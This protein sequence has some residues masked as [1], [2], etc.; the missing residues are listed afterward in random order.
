M[1]LKPYPKYKD[2]GIEWLGEIPEGWKVIPIRRI[3]KVI[4][5]ST[6]ESSNEEFWEGH[7]T[8]ITPEDLGNNQAKYITDSKR[9]ITNKGYKYC[10]TTLVP[11][12]SLIISTRAPIG[13]LALSSTESCF[14]QGCRGI[15]FQKKY[16]PSFYYYFLWATKDVLNAYGQGTTFFELGANKLA[17]LP[18]AVPPHGEQIQI[19]NYLDHQ[20]CKIDELIKK[21]ERLIELLKEK[22]QA[23][24]SHAV[25]KGLDPNAKMKDS[26]IEWLGEIPEGWEVRK[27]KY[28]CI[29]NFQ[30]GAN[31]EALDDNPDYPRYIRIT[32]I[33]DD[34]LRKDTF[35]SLQKDKA[36]LF[37]LRKGDILFARS[38]AT[39][40]KTFQYKESWGECCY[41]GYLIKMS[42]DPSKVESDFI[43]Y[44]TKSYS[45]NSWKTS[46]FIQAT[47]QNIS[48]EK[49]KDFQIC[50]PDVEEQ[51]KIIDFL[52]KET[53][54]IDELINKIQSQIEK[55][56][57]YRQSLISNVVTGKARVDEDR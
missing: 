18:V 34:N 44:F 49:Y 38:G 55:L 29:G 37:L 30:Y 28:L 9:K 39:V 42:P 52:N 33:K 23:I 20:T 4:N 11:K 53:N 7:I 47:I 31:E 17:S 27:L 1:N 15:V 21:N 25:T 3:G 22:R 8:W 2:S 57:E 12:N 19:S 46:I 26:G 56:K 41:A 45:Y 5:G 35:K 48:A 40:G 13:H 14:N 16:A 43:Y 50:L 10:G 6:P 54:R 51:R 36:K 24:I 32:D